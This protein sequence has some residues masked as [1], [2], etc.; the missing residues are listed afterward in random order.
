MNGVCGGCTEW[1]HQ[2]WGLGVGGCRGRWLTPIWCSAATTL[3]GA[4]ASALAGRGRC[5][6][7]KPVCSGVG[8]GGA[9]SGGGTEKEGG[10]G[11]ER[12]ERAPGVVRACDGCPPSPGGRTKQQRARKRGTWCADGEGKES[13]EGSTARG[14]AGVE[15]LL[16]LVLRQQ[17]RAPSRREGSQTEG[18]SAAPPPLPE[19]P[20][21]NDKGAEAHGPRPGTTASPPPGAATSR[22]CTKS[23]QIPDRVI[24]G[25]GG[26]VAAAGGLG[27]GAGDRR[28]GRRWRR[29]ARAAGGP[30]WGASARPRRAIPL[31]PDTPPG[32]ET[33]PP[34]P[35]PPPGGGGPAEGGVVHPPPGPAVDWCPRGT[36]P[37]AG[38]ATSY[39]PPMTFQ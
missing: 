5:L 10:D 36:A 7:V 33:P 14:P 15:Q 18:Q 16:R 4:P 35:T 26:W 1:L 3:F 23:L 30:S 31:P 39:I 25:G 2:S 12:A 8:E 24:F 27:G 32:I 13:R 37:E 21:H 19:S 34:A 11:W 6:A 22:R 29:G 17:P 9:S 28:G 38:I 20:T